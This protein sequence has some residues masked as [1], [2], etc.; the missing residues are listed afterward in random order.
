MIEHIRIPSL[1][2]VIIWLFAISCVSFAIG[3]AITILDGGKYAGTVGEKEIQVAIFPE[4]AERA[5]ISLEMESGRMNVSSGMSDTLLAGTIQST[6]ARNGPRQAY[7][8]TDGIGTLSISQ[9]SSILFDPLEKVD[10]WNFTLHQEI[11][12]DLSLKSG[13]GDINLDIGAAKMT[14]LRIDAGAGD[15]MVNLTRWKGSHLPVS[16]SSGLGSLSV[17]LPKETSIAAETDNGLGSRTISG[18]DGRDGQYYHTV[19]SPGSPV[20]SLSI[21]QGLGDL[22]LTIEP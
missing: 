10:N 1:R 20:I 6:Y 14:S 17:I 11:P 18:L 22:T 4:A 16:I 12:F 9:E 15:V 8:V 7:V 3:E 13:T 5:L 2:H 19:T 21:K